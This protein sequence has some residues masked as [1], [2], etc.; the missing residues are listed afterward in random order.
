MASPMDNYSTDSE[1][2][3]EALQ[4]ESSDFESGEDDFSIK[5]QHL[6]IETIIL[7]NLIIML[8]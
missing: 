8:V 5:L 6:S 3:N 2:I 1:E 4:C 7:N